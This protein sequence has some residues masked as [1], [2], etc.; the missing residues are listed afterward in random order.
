MLTGC[1]SAAPQRFVTVQT[2]F[3]TAPASKN[4]SMPIVS[5]APKP[6]PTSAMA[7]RQK[8]CALTLPYVVCEISV[9][10][11]FHFQ[12]VSFQ[13]KANASDELRRRA[14]HR[15]D[16]CGAQGALRPSTLNAST[17]GR[18]SHVSKRASVHGTM[19]ST[20]ARQQGQASRQVSAKLALF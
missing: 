5:R 2:A 9:R 20:S 7:A 4:R 13:R 8:Q 6:R 14:P 17:S 10:S 15:F 1:L 16:A 19:L 12:P 3:A 11:K 18:L